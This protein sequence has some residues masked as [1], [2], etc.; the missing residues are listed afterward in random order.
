MPEPEPEPEPP[1]P[2]PEPE[3]EPEHHKPTEEE[4]EARRAA[5]AK[6]GKGKPAKPGKDKDNQPRS[7]AWVG[8]VIVLLLIIGTL[9]G[10]VLFRKE[11]VTAVPA[12]APVFDMI[13]LGVEAVGEGLELRDVRSKVEK[14]G[15]V[16]ILIVEG[17]IHNASQ[18][19]R[20]IP[21]LKVTLKDRGG[22]DVYFWTFAVDTA[23]IEPGQS[24]PFATRL[25]SPPDRAH[26]M[27]TTFA[28]E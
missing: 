6:A 20:P 22:K 16:V 2:P 24:I 15:D 11:I 26:S 19:A 21:R 27:A 12:A 9:A 17:D 10:A 4:L 14:D 28:S 13:G 8:W 7:W 1:P 5:R 18:A 25:P 3:P 23:S